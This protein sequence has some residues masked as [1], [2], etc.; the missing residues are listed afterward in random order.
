MRPKVTISDTALDKAGCAAW[1]V[2]YATGLPF[3][4]AVNDIYELI[5]SLLSSALG[6]IN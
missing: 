4:D 3:F 2:I 6:Y 1:E 5:C